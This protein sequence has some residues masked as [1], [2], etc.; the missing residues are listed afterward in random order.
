MIRMG[1]SGFYYDDWVGP[2]YPAD[3]PRWQWLSFYA[4][5]FNTVELNVTY[6]RIPDTRTV[7]GWVDRTP[8]DFLFTV[9]ANRTITHEREDP[10]FAGFLEC[11]KIL[12]DAQKLACV[13]AQFP[14]AFRPNPE[15]HEYLHQLREGLREVPVVIEFRRSQWVR[16]ETFELLEKLNFG[17][18]CVD[19]PRLRGLMPPIAKATGPVAYVRFHGRN[20]EKWWNHDQAWERYDYTY[21]EQELKEWVSKIR[22]LDNAAPLVVV[23]ANN[24][25]RGQSVDTINKLKQLLVG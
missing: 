3:M 7:K 24:H 2:V 15:N 12:S 13:L 14:Y 17:F 16:S 4:D 22:D 8:A 18:C 20:A 21:S 23:Y 19:E 11:V 5:Q 10:D 25:Y 9:K 6:Y 1:T